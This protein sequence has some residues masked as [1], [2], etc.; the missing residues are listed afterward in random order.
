MVFLPANSL[1]TISILK[2]AA[3]PSR[4]MMI[5]L[6]DRL[7]KLFYDLYNTSP[8]LLAPYEFRMLQILLPWDYSYIAGHY[9]RK[10]V[11]VCFSDNVACE[12]LYE[13]L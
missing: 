12:S 9:E 6:L 11:L 13:F 8:A 4:T 2:E 1:L 5:A 10:Q 7:S 3:P